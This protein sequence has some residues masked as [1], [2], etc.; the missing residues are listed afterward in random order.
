MTTT[1]AGVT[2]TV[3]IATTIGMTATT[4][5]MTIVDIVVTATTAETSFNPDPPP[6]ARHLNLMIPLRFVSCV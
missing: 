3:T 5:M 1:M 6:V 2:V 4:M